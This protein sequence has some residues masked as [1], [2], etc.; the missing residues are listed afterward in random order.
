MTM[1]TDA[2]E[3]VQLATA[4]LGLHQVFR[5][6]ERSFLNPWGKSEPENQE[7]NFLDQ[8]RISVF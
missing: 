1:V 4:E 3:W 5:D 2:L 8:E 7:W 6:N